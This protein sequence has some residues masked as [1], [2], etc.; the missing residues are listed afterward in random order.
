MTILLGSYL[1][2]YFIYHSLVIFYVFYVVYVN[3][4]GNG[5]LSDADTHG[6]IILIPTLVFLMHRG[7]TAFKYST[8]SKTEYARVLAV[9][10]FGTAFKYMGMTQI[11]DSWDERQSIDLLFGEVASGAI[12]A[13]N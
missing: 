1:N 5:D 11:L 8:M 4:V 13:G 2:V 12:R 9:E 7:M 3:F 10:D 6:N